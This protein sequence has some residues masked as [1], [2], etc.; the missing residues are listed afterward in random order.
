MT[1]NAGHVFISHGSENRAEAERDLGLPRG[2]RH[3]DL[4]RAARRPPRH[5]L[6]GAVAERDRGVPRLRRAGH[7]HGQ[8]IA[9]CPRRDGDGVQQQ[10]ADLPGPPGATSSRPPASPSSSRSATGPTPIGNHAASEHGPPRRASCRTLSGLP[11]EAAAGAGSGRPPP[12]APASPPPPPPPPPPRRQRRC[13]RR[14]AAARGDRAQGRLL[15]RPLAGDG[16]EGQSRSSWNWAAC[17]ANVFWFAYRKMWLP[18]AAMAFA[19]LLRRRVRRGDPAARHG[20]PGRA[21]SLLTFVTG[22]LRQPPLPQPDRRARRRS[23]ARQAPSSSRAAAF[24]RRRWS[25]R[26]ARP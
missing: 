11:D 18:L 2:A 26:I 24:R 14:G 1:A 8:Q 10:Q 22:A 3:Q 21:R 13:R 4:D 12:T 5:G 23:G 16:R 25:P 17:L 19:I 20:Q 6:F 15:S 7:R 9:L